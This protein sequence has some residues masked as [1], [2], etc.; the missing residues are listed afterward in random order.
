[1]NITDVIVIGED[2]V[3]LYTGI[4]ACEKGY[5]VKIFDKSNRTIFT[6]QNKLIFS[7]NHNLIKKLFLKLNISIESI[8]F[9][10]QILTNIISHIEKMPSSLQQNITFL[11]AYNTLCK[12][13]MSI[14][15]NNIVEFNYLQNNKCIDAINYIK[16]N[17]INTKCF[18]VPAC[19][20][21]IVLKKMR[22]YFKQLNGQIFYNH[23]V[24]S[25]SQSHN[26][27]I[28]A[29]INNKLWNC[30]I[31]I[32]SF[33]EELHH[34]KTNLSFLYDNNIFL[35]I[36][37][38]SQKKYLSEYNLGNNTHFYK[39]KHHSSFINY[40]MEYINDVMKLI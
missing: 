24:Q 37:I 23:F 28:Q 32:N 21:S 6:K 13:N 39:I 12:N 4:R 8:S 38:P 40:T 9:N 11:Q 29:S 30:S 31:L 17:Y 18:Y 35:P 25:I 5:N 10:K 16:K 1:M 15:K 36:Y 27:Q 19:S 3:G 7:D 14:I 26:N 33:K 20:T 2:F 22:D 34:H